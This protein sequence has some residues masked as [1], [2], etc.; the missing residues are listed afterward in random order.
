MEL[1]SGA[2]IEAENM[3]DELNIAMTWLSYPGRANT[4]AAAEKIDFANLRGG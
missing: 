4:I 1:R 3:I 2:R